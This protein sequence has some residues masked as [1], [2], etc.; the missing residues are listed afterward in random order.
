MIFVAGE[1][2]TVA[3][4]FG[5][6]TSIIVPDTDAIEP[7]TSSS[8]FTLTG[9]TDVGCAAADDVTGVVGDSLGELLVVDPHATVANAVIPIIGSIAMRARGARCMAAPVN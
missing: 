9:A 6:L 1:N 2:D 8:P 7:A 5:P 4:P 3:D